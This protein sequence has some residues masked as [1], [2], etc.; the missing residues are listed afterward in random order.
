MVLVGFPLK[1]LNKGVFFD[2]I[3]ERLQLSGVNL[4]DPLT[5]REMYSAWEATFLD[6]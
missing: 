4:Y 5:K 6:I 3:T 1:P 2:P